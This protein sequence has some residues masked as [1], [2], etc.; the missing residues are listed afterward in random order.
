MRQLPIFSGEHLPPTGCRRFWDRPTQGNEFSRAWE[1]GEIDF[2]ELAAKMVGFLQ[3][4]ARRGDRWAITGLAEL[5]AWLADQVARRDPSF[6]TDLFYELLACHIKQ[7]R[8]KRNGG[9]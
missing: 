8:G 6:N 9:R 3:R 2:D 5:A 7:S 4:A 1:S